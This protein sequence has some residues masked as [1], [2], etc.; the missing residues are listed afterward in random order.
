MND[1]AVL[2]SFFLF[3]MG[4]VVSL[5]GLWLWRID[6]VAS[7]RVSEPG[8]RGQVLAFLRMI[9]EALPNPFQPP[10]AVRR[11]L[12]A[13]GYRAPSA[14]ALFYGS[15]WMVTLL[16]G[17]VLAWVGL[18][19]RED[20]SAAVLLCLCGLGFGYLI[21]DRVLE[22]LAA[23]RADRIDQSLPAALDLMV[24]SVEAGQ[25]L[26]TALF[27][28][29]REL[30]DLYPDLSGELNQVQLELRAGRSRAEVLQDLG[31][32]THSAELKKIAAILIDTDRFGT[33]LAPA[34]RT[35]ARYLRTSRRHAAQEAAR[36]LGV[37]LIFPVFFFIMP[38]VFVVT[39]GP[40][41]IQI[42]KTV[43]PMATS[44]LP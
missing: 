12:I 36:K 27:E 2:V 19:V 39:L 18:L 43:I 3:V 32:R 11:N 10:D 29:G 35:H 41:V 17:L 14:M 42:Y 15:K 4:M 22:S 23:R 44:A 21:P 1:S 24:L 34:L 31:Q 33:S 20:T 40:A 26:E 13:A 38:S 5:G 6:R 9:G 7:D 37:K 8:W 16:L 25:S 30:R 28:T